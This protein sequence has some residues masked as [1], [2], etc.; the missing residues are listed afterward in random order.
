MKH[1]LPFNVITTAVMLLSVSCSKSDTASPTVNANEKPSATTS[2]GSPVTLLNINYESGTINS[3]ISGLNTTNA[4]APD[5]SYMVTPGRTGSYA[6]AHKVILDNPGY[7]SDN[8]PRSESA[9]ANLTAG[10]YKVG[11]ERR[12]EFSVLLKNWTPYTT[13]MS[14][15]GDIIFQGKL[16]GGG[17]PAFYFMTKRNEIAFR[18]PNNNL[19]ISIVPDLRPYINQWMDFRVEVLWKND[20]SGYYKVYSKLPGQTNY[21]L[22][23][24]VS[25]FHTYLPD[26][27]DAVHGYNK[28][29]LYRPGQSIAN[30]DVPTRIIYHDN[31]KIVKL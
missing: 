22:I 30:G 2:A 13:G 31:I 23:W 11:D 12:Y 6:I 21:T 4:T 1:S 8:H 17:N 27:P 3:G 16:G 15:A 20:P 28:W 29:G 19:Q 18:M 26:N 10:Q 5:A 7:F 14:T 24:Q 9:T 25:N